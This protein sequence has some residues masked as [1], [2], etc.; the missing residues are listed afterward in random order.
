MYGE[1][2]PDPPMVQ[3]GCKTRIGLPNTKRH[4]WNISIHRQQIDD[5]Y[6]HERSKETLM[7]I[8]FS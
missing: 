7:K 5:S 6:G 1:R 4:D 8:N 2:Q 3:P